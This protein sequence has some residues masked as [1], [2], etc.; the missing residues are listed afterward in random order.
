MRRLLGAPLSAAICGLL[1][2]GGACAQV[3]NVQMPIGSG[4]PPG[5][6]WGMAG[7]FAQCIPDPPPTPPTPPTPPASSYPD[8][9]EISAFFFETTQKV[10]VT[11]T[12]NFATGGSGWN[13][14]SYSTTDF[15]GSAVFPWGGDLS[16][17]WGGSNP[18]SPAD[19]YDPVQWF[20]TKG[21]RILSTDSSVQGIVDA[22]VTV[23]GG[24]GTNGHAQPRYGGGD[25][26][27]YAACP[28]RVF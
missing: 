22:A 24:L 28:S 21:C 23:A 3:V 27:N 4:C 7:N 15:N 10:R 6:H 13:Q 5:Y 1:T 8:G 17:Y 9:Y 2:T 11:L 18:G 25:W 12:A 26:V 14:A 19:L 16:W 20:E